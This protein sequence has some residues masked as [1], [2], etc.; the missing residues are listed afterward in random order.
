MIKINYI[1]PSSNIYKDI[2]LEIRRI[3]IRRNYIWSQV[4]RHLLIKT[5]LPRTNGLNYDTN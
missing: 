2:P 3:E 5:K 1:R 4:W